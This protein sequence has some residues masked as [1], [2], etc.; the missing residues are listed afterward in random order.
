MNAGADSAA[1]IQLSCFVLSLVSAILPW[2]NG[3]PH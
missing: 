1:W 3:E 2:M